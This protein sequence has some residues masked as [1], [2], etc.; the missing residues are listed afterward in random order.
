MS[1]VE[2][3]FR[4]GGVCPDRITV[5]IMSNFHP[6]WISILEFLNEFVLD[7][8]KINL[9]ALIRNDKQ[10]TCRFDPIIEKKCLYVY[11]LKNNKRIYKITR[12]SEKYRG[13]MGQY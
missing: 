4:L 7:E 6:K 9:A 11:E 5:P 1:R 10:K 12:K 13:N 8:F 2:G 3:F